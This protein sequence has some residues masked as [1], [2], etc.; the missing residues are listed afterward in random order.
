MLHENHNLNAKFF[1]TICSDVVNDYRFEDKDYY[2][3]RTSDVNKD[4]TLK[5]KDKDQTLNAK[6]KDQ[7]YKDQDKDQ[8]PKDKDQTFKAKDQDSYRPGQGLGQL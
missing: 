2:G 7:T 4:L 6:D 5:D 1:K 3:P 8:T